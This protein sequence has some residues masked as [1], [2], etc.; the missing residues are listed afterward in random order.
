M[1]VFEMKCMSALKKILR[2][3]VYEEKHVC[4]RNMCVFVCVFYAK[5]KLLCA[6][7]FMCLK[8]S[9]RVVLKQVCVCVSHCVSEEKCSVRNICVKRNVCELY[10]RCGARARETRV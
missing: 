5:T 4:A 2:L 6:C 10:V 8:R 7:V 9:V 1:C 3:C